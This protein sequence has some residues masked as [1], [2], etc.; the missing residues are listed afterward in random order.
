MVGT[1]GG[2]DLAHAHAT[3]GRDRFRVARTAPVR[4]T[5]RAATATTAATAATATATAWRGAQAAPAAWR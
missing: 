5:G 2:H 1:T 3:L 4:R